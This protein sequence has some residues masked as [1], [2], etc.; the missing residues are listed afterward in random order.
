MNL[1]VK[2]LLVIML[3]GCL[4]AQAT[5]GPHAVHYSY[6][7]EAG[8]E[9][10]SVYVPVDLDR[11]Q[12]QFVFIEVDGRHYRL[13]HNKIIRDKAGAGIRIFYTRDQVVDDDGKWKSISLE[14][15][16]VRIL[17]YKNAQRDGEPIW[18]ISETFQMR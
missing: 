15:K 14:G 12:T 1:K 3:I 8:I 9:N 13:I 2:S 7:K 16:E 18:T 5:A 11:M 17:E 4:G 10:L 6:E